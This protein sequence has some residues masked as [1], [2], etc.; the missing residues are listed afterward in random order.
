M[1]QLQNDMRPP[2]P[3]GNNP[4]GG[5]MMVGAG[6]LG[7]MFGG[8]EAEA[9]LRAHPRISKYFDDPQFMNMW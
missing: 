2:M 1:Q 5:P 7:N 3:Q 9:K 8:P 4:F 6:G